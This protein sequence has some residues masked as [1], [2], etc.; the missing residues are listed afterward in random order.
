[1][2]SGQV[3]IV[4]RHARFSQ[5]EHMNNHSLCFCGPQAEDEGAGSV[6]ARA[7]T[8]EPRLKLSVLLDLAVDSELARLPQSKVRVMF[9]SCV[10]LRGAKNP[11]IVLP[12][13]EDGKHL[14]R[15]HFAVEWIVVDVAHAFHNIPIR[16]SERQFMCRKDGTRFLVFKV[17]GMGGKSSPNILSWFAAAVGCL[18]S[19]VFSGDEFGCVIFLDDPSWPP[20]EALMKDHAP[21]LT[22][23]WPSPSWV[24]LPLGTQPVSV[25]VWCGSA[26]S[27]QL[28]TSASELL[29]KVQAWCNARPHVPVPVWSFC[30]KLTFV[31]VDAATLR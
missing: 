19:S 24:S 3:S 17:L 16:L 29:S 30:G 28:K 7:I 25:T 6:S 27:S 15:V 31:A 11:R 2:G 18:V 22:S 8:A 4:S 13:L 20:E 21:S 1:M 9:T 10:K 14:G 12:R 26:P 23:C 5:K